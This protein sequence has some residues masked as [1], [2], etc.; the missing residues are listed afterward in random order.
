MTVR[1]TNTVQGDHRNAFI[2]DGMVVFVTR[3][4]KGYNFSGDVE[5]VVSCMW[6]VLPLQQGLEALVWE[7]N[8][9]S[10]PTGRK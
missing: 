4:H 5:L 3:Y 6:L 9:A 8:V 10:R 7:K 2:E 1:H